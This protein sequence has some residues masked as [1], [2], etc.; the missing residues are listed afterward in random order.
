MNEHKSYNLYLSIR[1][2]RNK[3]PRQDHETTQSL[4]NHYDTSY[5]YYYYHTLG[6][7][8]TYLYTY[9]YSLLQLKMDAF[10]RLQ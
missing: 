7:I 9:S 1:G 8:I 3:E 5:K 4:R 6:I 2:G 10:Y